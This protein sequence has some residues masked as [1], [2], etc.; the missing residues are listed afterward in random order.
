MITPC[1]T[2]LLRAP[3]LQSFQRA[4][5]GLIKTTDPWT[6]GATAV[7]LP[8]RAAAEQLRRTL[9]DLIADSI[10]ETS[11]LALPSLLT[12]TEWYS[13]MHQRLGDT[14]P[15]ISPVE[16]QVCA[17][18]AARQAARVVP[19]PFE[20]RLGLV[21]QII[22][23]YDQLRR[24]QC[25]VDSFESLVKSELEPTLDL[26][27]GA[28][29]LLRQT[30]FLAATFR[31]YQKRLSELNRL[32]EH[33]LRQLLTLPDAATPFSHVV[34]TI[35]DQA[36]HSSG[37]WPA[38]FDLLA[39]LPGLK[40]VDVLATDAVLEA[41]FNDRLTQMLPGLTVEHLDDA[42]DQQPVLMAPSG[43]DDRDYFKWRDREEELLGVV[44][45]LKGTG[46]SERP[47]LSSHNRSGKVID[48]REAV[49]FQRPLPYLYLAGQLFEQA[50]IPFET[51]DALPLAAEPY[52]AAI[53]L[54]IDCVTS[55][56]SRS[57][58]VSLLRSPHFAFEYEGKRVEPLE[59]E[60]FDQ[61]LRAMR[62]SGGREEFVRLV[63]GSWKERD[64]RK[65]AL[66]GVGQAVRVMAKIADELYEFERVT[67]AAQL[68]DRLATFLERYKTA[69][70]LTGQRMERALQARATIIRG[71]RE[72]SDAYRQFDA[73]PVEFRELA[74]SLRRWIESQTLLP[75]N[76]DGGVQL[77]DSETAPYG[78]FRQLFILG[79]VDGEWPAP[80]SRNV[81]YPPMLLALLGWP[82]ERDLI[83]SS[84][85]RFTD[86]T[87]LP[88]E[89]LWLSTFSLEDDAVVVPSSLLE[90]AVPGD[91]E[92]VRVEVDPHVVVIPD[93]ALALA[94]VPEGTLD[95]QP[96]RWLHLRQQRS[97]ESSQ[98]FHG[99]V[100]SRPSGSYSVKSLE[101]Y[102]ECP[103]KYFAG[104]LLD[105][106]DEAPEQPIL[107]PRER[108][109]LLHR[110]FETFYRDWHNTAGKSVTLANLDQALTRFGRIV[111][112]AIQDLQPTERT[113]MA[114]WLLGS[115]AAPGLAERLF[116]LEVLRPADVIERLV[117]FRIDG[118][119]V[120]TEGGR[121]RKV[122]LRGVVDRID[123][124][125]DGTF[126]LID[127]KTNKSPGRKVALQLPVYT[128][129]VEQQLDGH[130]GRS[131]QAAEAAYV[132]FG[133]ERLYI[134]L[135]R[136]EL[137]RELSKS[138]GR[139]IETLD[140]LENGVYPPRPAEL[141]HC[142]I[143]PFP[144]VCRKDYVGD[145]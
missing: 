69:D 55:G 15:L 30:T 126:R 107:T 114:A 129:C 123:L 110:V 90:N 4:I 92:V 20:V 87:S 8:T 132:A 81:L 49:V 135:A 32:D 22:D 44:R 137:S 141:Y 94:S 11:V 133:D 68:L 102:L 64:E 24:C 48:G 104:T 60:R 37:L 9:E 18:A 27:R 38:D 33:K 50:A 72:L 14:T 115:A 71:I 100:G 25:S 82:R 63:T 144:T 51:R 46:C 7:L 59:V 80:P 40:Q 70:V 103:F 42:D 5:V 52:A 77:V 12:R 41:G 61:V 136:S 79:M 23:F 139:V 91:Q 118:S 28:R 84:R 111:E 74:S 86:L 47:K 57:S 10:V 62:Y 75:K 116:L 93:D 119:F 3:S 140:E 85:A 78:R 36:V 56:Y 43:D 125:S 58:M 95:T 124:F 120:F 66:E 106:R 98:I 130:R 128:R 39:R 21:S 16:R 67:P 101:Q 99:I 34:I 109:L 17:L 112:L 89:R 13:V 35:G 131:W 6:A 138:D 88:L 54:V 113:V 2:R 108:G 97:D 96:E 145:E 142:R 122:R 19:P 26:D 134:P 1:R 73:E 53:D 29:R 143:C 31:V 117:E 76:Q 121:C 127:Y 65:S 105:L 83:R 45:F